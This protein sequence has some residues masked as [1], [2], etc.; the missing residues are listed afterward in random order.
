MAAIAETMVLNFPDPVYGTS[1]RI[2]PCRASGRRPDG[3]TIPICRSRSAD[4]TRGDAA[5]ARLCG[6]PISRY[7]P[8]DPTHDAVAARRAADDRPRPDRSDSPSDILAHA[9]PDDPD[10]DGI[11]GRP[12]HRARQP[13]G[14]TD[15]RPFRLEGGDAIDPPAGGATPLPAISAFRRRK[16]TARIG[17]CTE[18]EADCLA[19]PTGVQERLGAARRPT[20]CSTSSPSIRR[21]SRVPAR[22]EIGDPEVLA[23]KEAVL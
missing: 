11:S 7:G 17:D 19:L 18:A 3:S 23:G 8:L 10:G 13:S 6:R 21:T 9:D 12:Q 16:S 14:K 5:Q 2:S 4:G 15:A 20:R 1:C 22:R